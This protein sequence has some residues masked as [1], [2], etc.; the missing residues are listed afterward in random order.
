MHIKSGNRFQLR[1]CVPREEQ[2]RC[3]LE[4]VE[5]KNPVLAER[6]VVTNMRLVVNGAAPRM[7]HIPDPVDKTLALSMASSA[8]LAPNDP[9]C[10]K[11]SRDDGGD[12]RGRMVGCANRVSPRVRGGQPPHVV[13]DVAPSPVSS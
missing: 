4:Y 13:L 9:G 1:R 6:L 7:R 5:T 11:V 12:S 2:H 3:A 8:G 10:F